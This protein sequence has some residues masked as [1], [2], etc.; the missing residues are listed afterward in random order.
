[1]RNFL[2]CV[3]SRNRPIA[4]I[5]DAHYT[6]TALRLGNISYRVGR[7][8]QWDAVKEQVIGDAEANKL[9]VGTYRQPWA[10]KGL[11]SSL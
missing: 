6:N 3:K 9:V 7:M 10:P 1:M 4:D 5:E 8:L 11:R 2:D